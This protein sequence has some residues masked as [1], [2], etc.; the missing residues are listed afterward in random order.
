M[1]HFVKF[2]HFGNRKQAPPEVERPST[3]PTLDPPFGMA[4]TE[5]VEVKRKQHKLKQTLKMKNAKTPIWAYNHQ[6]H[7][8]LSL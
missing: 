8:R 2:E 3:I 4:D 7:H 6:G 1:S 5:F